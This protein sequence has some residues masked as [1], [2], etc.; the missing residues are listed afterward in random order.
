MR[1]A[2]DDRPGGRRWRMPV[3]PRRGGVRLVRCRAAPNEPGSTEQGRAP[4]RGAGPGPA[5]R[6]RAGPATRRREAP[7]PAAPS[8]AQ[9]AMRSTLP[10]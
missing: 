4:P 9:V 7:A 2:L 5:T 1:H 3:V 6:R 10:Q 8:R